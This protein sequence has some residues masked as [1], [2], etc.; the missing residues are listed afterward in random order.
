MCN[1]ADIIPNVGYNRNAY[2]NEL[3]EIPCAAFKSKKGE[4]K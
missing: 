3:S 2:I 1:I 4:N